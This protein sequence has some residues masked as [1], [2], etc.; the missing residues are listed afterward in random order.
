MSKRKK[1]L[2]DI[3]RGKAGTN[4]KYKPPNNRPATDEKYEHQHFAWR[5]EWTSDD[6]REMIIARFDRVARERWDKAKQPRTLD[7]IGEMEQKAIDAFFKAFRLRML[8][9]EACVESGWLHE[10]PPNNEK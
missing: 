6:I 10:I 1:Q 7:T 2:I 9:A 3:T 5:E 4:E 8:R